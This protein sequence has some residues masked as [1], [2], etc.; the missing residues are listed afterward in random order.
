MLL[1][2]TNAQSDSAAYKQ[3]VHVTLLQLVQYFL[4]DAMYMVPGT[5][6]GI[7][8]PRSHQNRQFPTP[9]TPRGS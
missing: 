1:E 6:Q 8:H 4:S 9:G 5:P 3:Y 7:S 2:L